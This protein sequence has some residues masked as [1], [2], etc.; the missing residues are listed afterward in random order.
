MRGT[1]RVSDPTCARW[2][3][4][5]RRRVPARPVALS[6]GGFEER[7]TA[8]IA[9]RRV[10]A[11]LI[12]AAFHCDHDEEAGH[13]REEASRRAGDS[14]ASPDLAFHVREGQGRRGNVASATRHRRARPR[15]RGYRPRGMMRTRGAVPGSNS[16]FIDVP[17]DK[18]CELLLVALVSGLVG[19][20]SATS[21]ASIRRSM[22][23]RSGESPPRW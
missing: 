22:A 14:E 6:V 2:F 9:C 5:S 4:S 23:P 12:D 18:R 8:G 10:P 7:R 13:Q 3:A 21:T 11:T 17:F 1:S 19:L 20:R 16:V 15:R